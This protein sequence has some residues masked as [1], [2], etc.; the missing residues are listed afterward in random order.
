MKE[1]D[2]M[3]AKAKA[4][5]GAIDYMESIDAEK[6]YEKGRKRIANENRRKIFGNIVRAAACLAIPLALSTAI[7]GWIHFFPSESEK[8]ASVTVP[9]GSVVRYEL[10]DNSIVWLNSLSTLK[11][12]VRFSSK[13][14]RVELEGE[15][16]FE[17]EANP[18]KPFYVN[19]SDNLAVRVY[20]TKFNVTAYNDEPLIRTTLESG[21]VEVIVSGNGAALDLAPGEQATYDKAT[22]LLDKRTVNTYE[23]TAWKQGR[24]VFR[25]ASLTDVF[26]SLERKFGVKI[27]V[28]GKVND[29]ETYRATFRNESLSQIMDYLSRT[30]GFEWASAD[31]TPSVGGALP[32]NDIVV[33][34][35]N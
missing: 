21:H 23:H 24:L 12:P 11:Y 25:N 31:R 30:A 22:G 15:A 4:I 19:T 7:L 13:A 16:Y 29:T 17:V 27:N 3:L 6:A 18:D 9:A 35:Q 28:Q 1:A 34:F 20:G 10:S 8:Y 14:R 32:E 33:K 26:K 5:S 2:K